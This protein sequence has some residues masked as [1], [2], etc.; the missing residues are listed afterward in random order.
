MN[1]STLAITVVLTR[2]HYGVFLRSGGRGD[3]QIERWLNR[4][5]IVAQ[6][7]V[8]RAEVDG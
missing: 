3:T 1:P 2:S 7:F 5:R 4:H 8:L 6:P